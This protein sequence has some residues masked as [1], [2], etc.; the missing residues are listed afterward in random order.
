MEA[1]TI[2]RI[3]PELSRHLRIY[4]GC[5]GR[6]QT[7][8]HLEE[9][10]RGQLSDLPR[11]SVEPMADAA[12]VPAR[13]LQEFLGLSRWNEQMMRDRLQ[14]K[15]AAD[16]ASPQSVGYFDETSFVKK[17]DKTACVQRQYCGAS[18]KKDNCVVSVHLGYCAGD[19]HTLLDGE[20]FLPEHT[21]D[22]DLER[23]REAG[24]PD[25]LAHR[26]KAQIA[27][28]QYRRAVANGVRFGWLTF[29][30]LYGRDG[31]LLRALDE[32]G[33]NYV[34]EVPCDQYVWTTEPQVLQRRHGRDLQPRAGRPREYPR[35]KA[36]NLPR[37][38]VQ[39]VLAYSPLLRKQAW[40]RYRVKDGSKGPMVWEAKHMLVWLAGE[41]GLPACGG[42]P[43]HLIVARN[44][45]EPDK[46]KYFISNA[47]P[48]T[49]MD[50]LMPVAFSRWRIERMFEDSK[51]ELGMDH[52][53]VRQFLSIQRHLILSCVSHLFLA[54]FWLRERGEKSGADHQPTGHGHTGADPAVAAPCSMHAGAGTGDCRPNPADPGTQRQSRQESSQSHAA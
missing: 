26:T 17:G 15:V 23:R 36:K 29:D 47:P 11:K 19:F 21:W 5:F 37:V 8:A 12:G 7:R 53:E 43:Y 2:Q 35:L 52:F 1:R 25:D 39:N 48:E 49:G 4:A 20:M 34:A 46:V 27:L 38:P 40:T 28:G 3:R 16:H 30:E 13:T 22:P 24:I 6:S 41:D 18:G 10:V 44:V 32:A 51:M 54:E 31:P 14:Q 42:R 45:L 50:T 9:Y 33:Q